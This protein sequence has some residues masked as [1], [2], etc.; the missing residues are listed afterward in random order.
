MKKFHV[1]INTKDGYSYNKALEAKNELEAFCLYAKE[2]AQSTSGNGYMADFVARINFE[3]VTAQEIG[4]DNVPVQPPHE[5][6][7]HWLT[8]HA[9]KWAAAPNGTATHNIGDRIT[10]QIKSIPELYN[11]LIYYGINKDNKGVPVVQKSNSYGRY[12]MVENRATQKIY[13]LYENGN[14]QAHSDEPGARLQ[15]FRKNWLPFAAGTELFPKLVAIKPKKKKKT[16]ASAK[17]WE[18]FRLNNDS[19]CDCEDCCNARLRRWN[20]EEASIAALARIGI[21]LTV[22]E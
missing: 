10:K 3:R 13:Y 5:L 12:C 17:T 20:E 22:Y 16:V 14:T 2:L 6:F 1:V 9:D 11:N 18:D 7:M 4:G 19:D 21:P 15:I 8:E